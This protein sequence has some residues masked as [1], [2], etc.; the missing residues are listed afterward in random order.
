[1]TLSEISI[2]RLLNQQLAETNLKTS[3][4]AVHWLGAVQAQEYAQTKWGLGLRLPHLLDADIE[5]EFT[6]GKILRTH[7]LRPTWHFVTAKDIRWMLMLTAPRVNAVNAYMHRKLE[8]NK[9]IFD[10]CN[11]IIIKKLEGGNQLTREEIN[12]EFKKHKIMATGHRLSYLMMDAELSGLICSG[13][14][15]GNQF[16]YA[17]LD[18]RVTQ[19]LT[20]N[21]D[22]ALSE[23][24]KRYFLSR[25]PATV[26]DFSTWS[27]LTIGECKKG[28]S[29]MK[30]FFEKVIVEGKEYYFKN[31]ISSIPKIIREIYLLP[32]YD[33]FIMGYKDRSAS[34]EF[35]K[36]L[37]ITNPAQY[38]C[39]IVYEGQI[40]GTWKRTLKQKS[41]DIDYKLF[42]PL[43]KNQTKEFQKAI[44]RL[45]KFHQIK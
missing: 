44:I 26:I 5:K 10:R 37:N 23:L 4:D 30:E 32:I 39:M 43:N 21:Y 17:L 7:L 16:T 28:L 8:L 20:L 13:P 35:K 40:I 27:G 3:A 36:S 15:K 6:D 19:N 14:R 31:T 41:I 33:E 24:T 42:S 18:E 22:E 1:V 34:F 25:G 12:D 11:K 2:Y 45:E 38:D 29:L 9:S